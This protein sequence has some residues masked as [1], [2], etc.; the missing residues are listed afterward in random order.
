MFPDRP[1]DDL[2]GLIAGRKLGQGQYREVYEYLPDLDYVIKVEMGSRC[3]S[4][5]LEWH[6]W[7]DMKGLDH[8]RKW[9]AP[10]HSISPNGIY[11]LQR[12]TTRPKEYPDQVPCWMVDTK[13]ANFG[14]LSTG[15]FVA[16]DYA[17]MMTNEYGA[18]KRMVKAKWWELEP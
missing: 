9:L 17:G 10:C 3:F 11:L 1:S 5:A 16:H 18:S 13:R 6:M 14:V 12:R 7:D 2:W 8:V 15:Q 4:N